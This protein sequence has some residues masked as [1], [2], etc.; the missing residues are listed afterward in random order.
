[1]RLWRSKNKRYDFCIP[2]FVLGQNVFGLFLGLR[3]IRYEI[4][5][6]NSL[7]EVNGRTMF[8]AAIVRSWPEKR[9]VLFFFPQFWRKAVGLFFLSEKRPRTTIASKMWMF[10]QMA[11]KMA[12]P[13]NLN[14]YFMEISLSS[15]F[16]KFVS[17]SGFYPFLFMLLF[18]C[19][20]KRK[21]YILFLLPLF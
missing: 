8:R 3:F 12:C 1:M 9:I 11:F 21:K 15:I 5:K 19:G 7:E 16:A 10:R 17:F 14:E 13:G 4:A 6:R 20:K 18:F 2:S